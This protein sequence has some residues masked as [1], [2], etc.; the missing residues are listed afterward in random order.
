MKR[1]IIGILCLILSAAIILGGCGAEKSADAEPAGN[2]AGESSGFVAA[3]VTVVESKEEK[4][5]AGDDYSADV[6]LEEMKRDPPYDFNI[7][8]MIPSDFGDFFAGEY[9]CEKEEYNLLTIDSITNKVTVIK[10]SEP[11]PVIYVVAGIHGDEEA[12]WQTGNLLTRISIKAGTLYVLAP[13]NPWG[14]DKVPKSRYVNGGDPNRSFPG[15]KNGSDAEKLA[16]AIFGDVSDKSPDFV[17]DLHEA[18]IVSTERDYL[19]SSFVYSDLSLMEDMFF[20]LYLATQSSEICSRPFT[21]YGPGPEGS[22]NRT[23]TEQLKIPVITV[24]TF[25]GY[26]MENRISD[27]LDAVQYVLR[28][29]GMVE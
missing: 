25:R 12:A 21:Y 16:A 3:P 15:S 5:S 27:Q 18:T 8:E 2:P 10:G 7:D 1:K 14:V 11:G 6:S 29:Y 19:G 4:Q 20:D 26:Q 24:E 22:V 13:A 9:A 23:I 28:Y 17:F